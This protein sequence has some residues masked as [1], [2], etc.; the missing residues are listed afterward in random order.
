MTGQ[1]LHPEELLRLHH[2][3]SQQSY[4]SMKFNSYNSVRD[5]QT[6]STARKLLNSFRCLEYGKHPKASLR[7][8]ASFLS[9]AYLEHC[10]LSRFQV[11][12]DSK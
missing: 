1:Q 8:K 6:L 10:C 12:Q 4:F 9:Q 5:A 7:G 2:A 3:L 11:A